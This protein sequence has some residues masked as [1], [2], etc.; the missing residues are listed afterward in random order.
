[1][2]VNLL[3]KRYALALFELS[4]E[5]KSTDK[6][7][8]DMSFIGKVLEQNRE[9]RKVLEN[10]VLDDA[11][12]ATL[13]VKIFG[14]NIQKL[15][16]R[17]LHLISRKGRASYLLAICYAFGEIYKEHK[18]ILSAELITAIKADKEIRED[19]I[20]KLKNITDKNIELEEIVDDDIIGG[21]VLRMGDYQYDA[22]IANQLN[23]LK[24]EFSENLYVKQF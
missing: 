24:K 18:N 17:F 15:T 14:N 2:R 9:L 21:F 23:R 3:A 12:K 6:I 13:L 19:I 5:D 10:P 22:S 7:A 20:T 4:L 16:K 1:M 8:K 11:K